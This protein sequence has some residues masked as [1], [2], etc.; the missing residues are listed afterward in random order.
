MLDFGKELAKGK[1]HTLTVWNTDGLQ[2]TDFKTK[3]PPV[4]RWLLDPLDTLFFLDIEN[5][6]CGTTPETTP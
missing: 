6:V 5:F 2:P 1:R 3:K 4:F